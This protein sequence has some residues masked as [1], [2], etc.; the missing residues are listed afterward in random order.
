M[1]GLLLLVLTTT[2]SDAIA[3]VGLGADVMNRYVWRGADFGNSPSIQP[4]INFTSGNFEIGAWAAF[5]TNGNPDGTEVDFYTS[6]TFSTSRG[7]LSLMLTDYT[8]PQAPEGNYFSGS[9]HFLE[10]GFQYSGTEQ[11]PINLFTGVFLTNDDD[12]S[13]YTQIGYGI[14]N[15]ELFMGFTP[16]KSELYGTGKAGV[17]HT[18]ISV[19]N[20]VPVTEFFSVIVNGTLAANPYSDNFFFLFGIGF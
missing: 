9:A 8:F 11:F 7:D 20:P 10:A 1:C 16:S 2:A 13:V 3:Q 12:T 6:Y 15:V 17:I 4:D 14:R 18:G 19:T 5:A